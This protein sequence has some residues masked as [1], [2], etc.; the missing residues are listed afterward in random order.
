VK[1]LV[2]TKADALEIS[3]QSDVLDGWIGGVDGWVGKRL[4]VSIVSVSL[5]VS[6]CTYVYLP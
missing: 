6:V 1:I 3:S 4:C 2:C 5:C